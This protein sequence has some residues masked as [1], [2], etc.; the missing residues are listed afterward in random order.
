MPRLMTS[1]MAWPVKPFH[2]PL[3]T[4]SV[5]PLIC[6]R[7]RFTSGITYQHQPHS[8]TVKCSHQASPTNTRHTAAQW[9]MFKSGITYQHR[10][11]SITVKYVHITHHLPTPA[12]QHHNWITDVKKTIFTFFI[13]ATF[14][15]FLKCF[16][17]C[18]FYFKLKK[19][20]I[21]N[22]IKK[23]EKHFW[24][25]K[26]QKRINRPRFYYESGWVQSSSVPITH[27]AYYVRQ[28][29]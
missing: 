16:L 7:T 29:L 1:V 14:F 20:F 24:K 8:S 15:T 11:H 4:D 26:Q 25:M 5:K 27:R 22:S 6:C 28:C 9:N 17:F 23:F 10:P 19:M 21:E 3:R 18:H 2:S 12:T 13:P